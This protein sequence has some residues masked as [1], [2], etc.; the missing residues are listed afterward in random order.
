MFRPAAGRT[1][2]S[3]TSFSHLKDTL[4]G[5]ESWVSLFVLHPVRK[6][7]WVSTWACLIILKISQHTTASHANT[8]LPAQGLSYD[9]SSAVITVVHSGL[10]LTGCL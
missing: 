9:P 5:K 1:Y 3:S 8:A 10:M 2:N 7:D 6:G 4:F